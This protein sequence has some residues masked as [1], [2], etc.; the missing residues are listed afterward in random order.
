MDLVITTDSYL[1]TVRAIINKLV[2][3]CPVN[4]IEALLTCVC[5]VIWRECWLEYSFEKIQ[6]ASRSDDHHIALSKGIIRAR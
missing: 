4:K 5:E 6:G 2:R 1:A 3:H